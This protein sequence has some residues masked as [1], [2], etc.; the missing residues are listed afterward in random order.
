MKLIF[1]LLG[2]YLSSL[3]LLCGQVTV[4]LVLEDEYFLQGESILAGVRITNLSGQ[5]LDLGKDKDWLTFSVEARDNFIVPM[6]DEVPVLG[7]FSVESTTAATKKVDITPCF[8]LT[9]PGRYTVTARIKIPQWQ[10]ELSTKSK[11]FVISSVR[12]LWEQE[13]GVPDSTGA[14][15]PPEVRKYALQQAMHLKEKK[16]YVRVTDALENKIF[17]VFPVGPVV[18]PTRPEPQLD[19]F[20]N[21]HLLFQTG[22]RAFNYS[23]I[24]PEGQLLVRQTHEYTAGS[25][26]ALKP[27]QEGNIRVVGGARRITAND[28]PPHKSTPADDVKETSH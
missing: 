8:Q 12:K 17:R 22:A 10:Q 9:T 5:T 3:S 24:N 15:A 16:L 27:D 4:E 14:N 11:P 1:P 21:L 25:R 19:K 26:P 7:Q 13:F 6:L 28:L 23:V 20:G 2:C 18:G